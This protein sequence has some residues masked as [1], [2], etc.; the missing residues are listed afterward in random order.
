M[1]G[2][3]RTVRG[4]AVAWYTHPDGSHRWARLGDVIHVADGDVER[5][6]DV[7]GSVAEPTPA[8]TSSIPEPPRVGR[9]SSRDAW[10]AYAEGLGVPVADDASRDD[11]I[12]AVDARNDADVEGDEVDG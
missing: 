12:A 3:Q 5:W 8:P 9:G 11:I 2:H 7:E 1:A 6:D 10:A 4:H